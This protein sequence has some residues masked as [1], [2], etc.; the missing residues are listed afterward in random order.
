MYRADEVFSPVNVFIIL[1]RVNADAHAPFQPTPRFIPSATLVNL[2]RLAVAEMSY[3]A[4][5]APL[6]HH[7]SHGPRANP[8]FRITMLSFEGVR[9]P[10]TDSSV[11][12]LNSKV[13]ELPPLEQ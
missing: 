12:S 6:P 8:G 11:V 4:S 9:D 5:F 7:R 1:I 2:I 3:L 10:Y 13:N